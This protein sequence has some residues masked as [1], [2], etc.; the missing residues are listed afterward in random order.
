MPHISVGGPQGAGK[1]GVLQEAL[2]GV[3]V[4]ARDVCVE[5]GTLSLPLQLPRR[6][7]RH[8]AGL[9]FVFDSIRGGRDA[10]LVV[11]HISSFQLHNNA[12]DGAI[13][14]GSVLRQ[15]GSGWVFK[16]TGLDQ[17]FELTLELS[18]VEM[19]L[20]ETGSRS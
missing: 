12:G 19:E 7:L 8:L 5:G 2:M 1:P 6:P 9:A 16:L 17:D 13:A 18:A 15:A 11:A 3:H 4:R 14:C 20:F 10:R